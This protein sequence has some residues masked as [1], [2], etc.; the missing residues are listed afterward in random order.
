MYSEYDQD[1]TSL[2]KQDFEDYSSKYK[3]LAFMYQ[4]A[5]NTVEKSSVLD[6]VDFQLDL[7]FSDCI[8]VD[9][10]TWSDR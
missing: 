10:T 1:T 8:N 5:D 4:R 7:L 9:Y 2:T 6:E 3:D